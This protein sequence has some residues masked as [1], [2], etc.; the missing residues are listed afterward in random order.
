MFRAPVR[1]YRWHLGWLLGS[2]FCLLTHTGR[3]TGRPRQTVL[4]VAGRDPDTG[5]ILVASGFGRASQWYRNIC[6][7]ARV[8]VRVGRRSSEALAR[9]FTPDESGR[10]MALYASRHPRAAR[11]LLRVCG[12]EAGVDGED[13]YAVGHDFIPFV[14]LTPTGAFLE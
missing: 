9:P 12:V 1:L 11:Q 5:A 13:F 4:E 2:R 14:A 10:A 3:S 6:Q 7:D 8:H